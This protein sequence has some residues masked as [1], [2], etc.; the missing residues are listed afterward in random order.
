[1]NTEQGPRLTITITYCTVEYSYSCSRSGANR[2]ERAK[3]NHAFL[4][5]ADE[6]DGGE[7]SCPEFGIQL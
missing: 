1:M 3:I 4:A 5:R 7:I 2:R 6:T